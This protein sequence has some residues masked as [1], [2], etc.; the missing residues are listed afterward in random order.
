[1]APD[2]ELLRRAGASG[3]DVPAEPGGLCKYRC[4]MITCHPDP[5]PNPSPNPNPDPEPEQ[6]RTDAVADR[7]VL[8]GPSAE[9]PM[10]GR[11]REYAAY[12]LD[13]DPNPDPNPSPSP[14]P[15]SY[16]YP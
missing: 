13:P 9:Q 8:G 3:I 12:Q 5:D 10:P 16:P 11:E 7:Y 1:M 15:D 2:I 6:V 14:S 4:C